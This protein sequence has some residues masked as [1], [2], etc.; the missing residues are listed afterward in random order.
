MAVTSQ[1]PLYSESGLHEENG[2][3]GLYCR[4]CS[5]HPAALKWPVSCGGA[6][7]WGYANEQVSQFL[8]PL[9]YITRQSRQMYIEY[10][11]Y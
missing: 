11:V 3:Q 5:I 2:S 6:E 9:G 10:S 8:W 4:C 7:R 1:I